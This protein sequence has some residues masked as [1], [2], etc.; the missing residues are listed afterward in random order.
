MCIYLQI[1]ILGTA[2]FQLVMPSS[3]YM[4]DIQWDPVIATVHIVDALTFKL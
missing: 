4:F 2:V 3:A 1:F